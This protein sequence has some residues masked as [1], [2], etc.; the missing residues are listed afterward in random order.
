MTSTRTESTTVD[1]ETQVDITALLAGATADV[2]PRVNIPAPIVAYL[3]NEA[4]TFAAKTN[5]FRRTLVIANDVLAKAILANRPAD[6]KLTGADDDGNNKLHVAAAKEFARQVRQYAA[7]H[8]LSPAT[9][10]TDNPFTVTFRLARRQAPKVSN[11]VTVTNIADAAN[12]AKAGA[13]NAANA[14]KAAAIMAAD[15]PTRTEMAANAAS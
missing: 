4:A 7:D 2:Q 9:D 6:L 5:R 13:E 1:L 14:A 11:P 12:A 10:R 8:N 3:R 15:L